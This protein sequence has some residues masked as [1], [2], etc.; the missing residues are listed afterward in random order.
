MRKRSGF[1]LI[2][3]MV[4]IGIISIILAIAIPDFARNQQRAR[5]RSGAQAIA[6]DFRQIRERALSRG[7]RFSITIPDSRHYQVTGPGGSVSSFMLG[8]TTG[9]HLRFGVTGGV[10]S[11]PPEANQSS[12]PTNGFDFPGNTL[13]FEPFGA[14]SKG[15]IYI[16]DG[17]ANFAVGIN[18]IGRIKVYTYGNG[19]WVSL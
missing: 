13:I 18:H 14:A 7:Q 2:E 11:T 10:S 19:S 3:L 17:R 15:V 16:T 1:S 6:Q 5:I 12:P 4:V 9:G 8:Q